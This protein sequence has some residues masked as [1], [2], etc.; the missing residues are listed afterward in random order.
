MSPEMYT[1]VAVAIALAGL[2]GGLR[3]TFAGKA[4]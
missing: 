1:I 3:Y 2:V 4:V